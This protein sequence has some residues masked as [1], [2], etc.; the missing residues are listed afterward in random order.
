MF[1]EV[2]S[3][4]ERHYSLREVVDF[5]TF[6]SRYHRIQ[7]SSDLERAM[8]AIASILKDLGNIQLQTYVYSYNEK[9]GVHLPVMGWDV[10]EG[11]I[12]MIKPSKR[13]MHTFINSKTCVVAHSPPGDVEAPVVYVG[14]GIEKSNYKD[15]DGK[16]VLAYG[17]PYLVYRIGS[18][19]GAKGFIF[20]R[21]TS[22]GNAVPYLSLFLTS[23]ESKS[24]TAPAVSISYNEAQ[25]IIRYLEK[26][27]E[28]IVRIFVDS[29][30]R[31]DAKIIVVEACIGEGDKELHI[32][33]HTCHP[34]GTINDNI[35]GTASIL[36]LLIA[37]DRAIDR[38]VLAIPKG[39]KLVFI[40]FPEYYGSLPYLLE[41]IEHRET[42]IDFS[43]NLDMIG[44]R[45]DITGSTLNIIRPPVFLSNKL[46]ESIVVASLMNVLATNS[47]FSNMQNVLS[48]RIDI[49]PYDGGSDHDL[50]LQFNIPSIM[51]NQWPDK[52]YHTDQDTIDK[53]DPIIASR[54]SMAIGTPLYVI[55]TNSID[56]TLLSTTV[57]AYEKFLQGYSKLKRVFSIN[58][59]TSSSNYS[60]MDQE[61]QYKYIGP[62]GIISLRYLVNVLPKEM[63]SDIKDIISD[64][65]MQFL[66]TRYIPLSLMTSA[67]KVSDIK[68]LIE[69][70]YGIRVEL[71]KIRK[72]LLY[73]EKL[74]L[75]S[76]T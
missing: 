24:F 5:A 58:R 41:K 42:K 31:N 2:F 27:E 70:E 4:L 17:N 25:R 32:Y 36:E 50:Y 34:A 48:Y 20:F 75:V 8:M 13:V 29:V 52:F 54:I 66:F 14:E 73:L 6:L 74:G 15:A 55:A 64:N 67:R 22:P 7:G 63:F 33:A 62:K 23:D 40:W 69:N 49:V 71:N 76:E 16:I 1:R 38:N 59:F 18:E 3:A 26:G 65:F 46:Y 43:I 47:T 11:F 61:K 68:E 45:Q 35:S 72:M 9:Y 30:F 39:M 28:V 19:L 60:N 53:F 10:N 21:T 37:F 56:K 44:E 57:E 51:L 12:E